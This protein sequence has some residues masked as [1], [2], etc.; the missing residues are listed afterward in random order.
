MRLGVIHRAENGVDYDRWYVDSTI[1]FL[2]ATDIE[3]T[4]NI[5]TV[6]YL[7]TCITRCSDGFAWRQGKELSPLL[8]CAVSRVPR[9][10]VQS[11]ELVLDFQASYL[12]IIGSISPPHPTPHVFMICTGT[13]LPS[14]EAHPVCSRIKVKLYSFCDVWFLKVLVQP[15]RHIGALYCNKHTKHRDFV[16]SCNLR[17]SL[18]VGLHNFDVH[19]PASLSD[20]ACVCG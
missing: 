18:S 2:I 11:I 3:A 10:S 17:Q 14:R 19:W 20:V 8:Q 4:L 9:L 12:R 1:I 13:T 7:T 15:P 16:L 6:F 5:E